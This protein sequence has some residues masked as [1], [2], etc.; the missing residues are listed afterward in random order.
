M[1]K[2]ELTV[3]SERSVKRWPN[4]WIPEHFQVKSVAEVFQFLLV[5]KNRNRPAST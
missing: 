3:K 2:P 1:F 4:F 5:E